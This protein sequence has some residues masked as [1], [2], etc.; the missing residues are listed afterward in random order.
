MLIAKKLRETNIAEYLLY[1]WQVE[2]ILRAYN[3]D[4]DKLR[5]NYLTQFNTDPQTTTQLEEWYTNLIRMMHDEGKTKQGHLQINQNT[6]TWLNDLH[7]KLLQ[8]PKY[9]LY[10]AAYYKILPYII[11][12]RQKGDDNQVTEL[13]NCFNALYGVMLLRLQKHPIN[14]STLQATTDITKMLSMLS[15]YYTQEKEEKLK[16]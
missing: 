5:N 12:L 2:D 7:T 8:S 6:M 4:I 15:A 11:E 10:T 9:P 14:Q 1:M 3:L 16:F 13:E